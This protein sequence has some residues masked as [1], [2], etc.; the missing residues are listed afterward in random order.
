M[1]KLGDKPVLHNGGGKFHP[2][3]RIRIRHAGLK[4]LLPISHICTERYHALYDRFTEPSAMDFF[5]R[6]FLINTL[7]RNWHEWHVL[8][9]G[10]RTE[11]C[12]R[13]ISR[14]DGISID[15]FYLSAKAAG[16][17][18]GGRMLKHVLPPSLPLQ[19]SVQVFRPN[20]TAI[21]FFTRHKF[22]RKGNCQWRFRG[23]IQTG[24]CFVRPPFNSR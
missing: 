11:G 14:P 9:I 24:V 13:L 5:L 1:T 4:D 7:R 6:P 15:K 2:D 17:R 12:I 21:R 16:R 19:V 18:L 3:R 20:E 8:C 23:M 10:H 22:K